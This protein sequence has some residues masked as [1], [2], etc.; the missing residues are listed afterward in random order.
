MGGA[1]MILKTAAN[2]KAEGRK[3]SIL[4]PIS[5]ASWPI[6]TTAE[7]ISVVIGEPVRNFS[8]NRL[9]AAVRILVKRSVAAFATSASD[10]F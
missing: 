2:S 5:S 7:V 10:L 1:E 9:A 3:A 6:T 8:Q 4:S